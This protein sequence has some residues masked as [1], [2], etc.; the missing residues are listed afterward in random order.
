[1]C[2]QKSIGVKWDE[3]GVEGIDK[4]RTGE[5]GWK[6]SVMKKWLEYPVLWKLSKGYDSSKFNA[7]FKIFVNTDRL[8]SRSFF[9]L[10]SFEM[11]D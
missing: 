8:D 11:I 6:V 5:A 3:K 10:S 4:R 9:I 1:M 2:E 7:N